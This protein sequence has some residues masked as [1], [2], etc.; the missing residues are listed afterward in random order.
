MAQGF[1]QSGAQFYLCPLLRG[2]FGSNMVTDNHSVARFDHISVE[3]ESQNYE[4]LTVE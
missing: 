2:L 1:I 3:E 4:D